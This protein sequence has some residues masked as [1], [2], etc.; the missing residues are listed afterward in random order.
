[1]TIVSRERAGSTWGFGS[2]C[3]APRPPVTWDF[4][5]GLALADNFLDLAQKPRTFLEFRRAAA[6]DRVR[7]G[8]QEGEDD[9]P[10]RAWHGKARL[11]VKTA[12]GEVA[13]IEKRRAA[14]I[15]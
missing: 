14:A 4:A 9:P 5:G 2:A 1:M 8:D 10:H 12:V 13:F 6:D 3:A 7:A 11:P 15:G